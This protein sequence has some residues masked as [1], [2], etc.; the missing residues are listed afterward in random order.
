MN[1]A[2]SPSL[3]QKAASFAARVADQKCGQ[4]DRV[5]RGI[6]KSAWHVLLS[7]VKK[8]KPPTHSRE[9]N[10]GVEKLS[11]LVEFRPDTELP[12]PSILLPAVEMADRDKGAV[13]TTGS[14]MHDEMRYEELTSPLLQHRGPGWLE[15]NCSLPQTQAANATESVFEAERSYTFL[16]AMEDPFTTEA[17]VL[18]YDPLPMDIG[19]TT[20]FDEWLCTGESG[21][22][23]WGASWPKYVDVDMSIYES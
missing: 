7:T 11:Q 1:N 8:V 18:N 16:A 22:R 13:V 15:P 14:A 19:S 12:R 20:T 17:A 23:Y 2:E 10:H 3:R 4:Y 6:E 9:V 21:S 5:V